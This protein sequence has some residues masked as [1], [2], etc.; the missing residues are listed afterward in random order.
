MA[1]VD[2]LANEL[3]SPLAAAY[4]YAASNQG[5]DTWQ[6]EKILMEVL[7]GQSPVRSF[8]AATAPALTDRGYILLHPSSDTTART[9]TIP[10]NGSVAF[11]VGSTFTIINQV[12]GG[13][14]TIAITTD[15]LTWLPAGT[16]GSRTLAANG[17]ATCIKIT[18]T[19]WVITG[20]GLT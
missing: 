14:I 11:P 6:D 10:A 17:M 8:S 19:N 7:I 13:V 2:N 12:S 4:M 16:T 3:A 20:V 9:V 5:G 1:L 18:S 15:T